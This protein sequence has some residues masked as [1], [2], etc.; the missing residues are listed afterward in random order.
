[1]TAVDRDTRCIVGWA[2]LEKRM[3][4]TMQPVIDRAPP[5]RHYFS[6]DFKTYRQLLYL[7][8]HHI[9]IPGGKTETYSVEGNNADLRH[10][11]ARLRRRSRCFSRCL[12]ALRR[13][14]KL[15]VYHYNRRQL[16]IQQFPDYA[17]YPS[18]FVSIRI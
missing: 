16:Y 14:I 18:D 1:M 12:D 17:A 6:D 4:E 2:V 15:F 10:Y 9:P 7:G 5:A 13:A 3:Y 8:G 11:L